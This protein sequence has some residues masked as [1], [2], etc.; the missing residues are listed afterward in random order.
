MN[1]GSLDSDVAVKVRAQ[2]DGTI[3][4][5][6]YLDVSAQKITYPTAVTISG[7]G[8]VNQNGMYNYTKALSG[9]YNAEV[10]NVAWSLSSNNASTL[11]SQDADGATVNV[12]NTPATSIDVTLECVVTFEG[13]VTRTGTKTITM[14]L[15]FPSSVTVNGVGSIDANGDF[16]YTKTINGSYT[17]ALTSVAWS[18]TSNQNVTI[19]SSDDNGAVVSVPKGNDT[20]VTLTLTCTCTFSGGVTK[21]GTKN[22]SVAVIVAPPTIVVPTPID[23]GLPS[24]RLWASWNIG[25]ESEEEDGAYFSW[26]NIEP[27]FPNGTTFSYNWGSSNTGPYA[28]T[29]GASIPFTSQTKNADYSA[30]SG[31]DAAR[32]LFGGSWRMPTATEF[33]ELYDNTDNEW[34]TVNGVNGRKFMKKTDHSVYVFFPAA[35]NGRNTS[36]RSRG[37]NGRYWSSSLY[38]ADSGY[39]LGFDSSSATSQFGSYR[40]LGFSVRAVQ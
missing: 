32:E 13:G 34:T 33:Q 10:T 23:L 2:V 31:Y 17:A 7:N 40:Y 15:T 24:G 29:P 39:Y 9:T 6:S 26:G 38:P 27:N 30:D 16:N 20:A 4:Y 3:S 35:G 18:L 5:S 22:I 11:Y 8:T 28:S 25:A 14:V 19:K 12:T 36:L 37:S 21:T 1:V